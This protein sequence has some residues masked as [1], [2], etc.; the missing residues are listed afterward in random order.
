MIEHISGARHYIADVISRNPAGLTQEQIIKPRD[1]MVGVI[2]LNIDPQVKAILKDLEAHQ[3]N[4]PWVRN[5][6]ENLTKQP[7]PQTSDIQTV[8][9]NARA[10][11]VIHSGHPSYG[12]VWRKKFI[13][14]V[15]ALLG[16][17]ASNKCIAQLANTFFIKNLGRKVRKIISW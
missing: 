2:N 1:I 11:K 10:I 15:H 14:F 13:T 7:I 12:L 8:E 17:A 3:S 5:I 4:G 16:H 6:K 9:R